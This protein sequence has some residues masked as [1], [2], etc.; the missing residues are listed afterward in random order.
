MGPP[1]EAAARAALAAIAPSATMICSP[2][3]NTPAGIFGADLVLECPD[4][5]DVAEVV[6]AFAGAHAALWAARESRATGAR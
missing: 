2:V 6:F 3:H 1:A 5:K 4:G